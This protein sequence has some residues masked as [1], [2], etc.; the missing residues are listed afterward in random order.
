MLNTLLRVRFL[1]IG[2]WLTGASRKKKSQS[3]GQLIG[4]A[5]LMIYAFGALGFM[6]WHIF[7]TIAL[8]FHEAGL[9][10]LYF[11]MLL[12]MAFALMFVGSVFTAKAQLFEAKDNDLLLSLPLKPGDILLS[13]MFMLAVI[14]LIFGLL[15]AVPAGAVWGRA[16]GFSAAS[17][18][19]YMLVFLMLVLLALAL[20]AL[21]GWLISLLTA[22][23][24]KKS[25]V[26]TLL[27]LIF[28]GAYMYCC[29]N[30]NT[31]I[32]ELAAKPDAAAAAVGAVAPLYRLS[33]AVAA[34]NLLAALPALLFGA[35][36]FAGTYL[37]LS[38]TFMSAAAGQHGGKKLRYVERA[39]KS[40]SA[41]TALFRREMGRFLSC[42]AYMMNSGLGAVMTLAG[43]VLLLIKAGSVRAIAAQMPELGGLLAPAAVMSLCLLSSMT[44]I[45]SP[46]VSLEGRSIW[47]AQSLPVSTKAVLKAKLRL[48]NTI[49]LIPVLFA[50]LAAAVVVQPEGL[51][52]VLLFVLPCL[53]S[54]FVGILGLVENLRHPNLD[55]TNET[56]AVKSGIGVMLTMFI[57]WLA[58][59]VPVVLYF[60]L[61][62]T[63]DASAV[64]AVFS[65]IIA[66]LCALMYRW[67]MTRGTQVYMGL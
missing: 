22:R 26:T 52:L 6:F 48:H 28:L 47:I 4:F 55:W 40:V 23:V 45:S 24:Q 54:V 44:L 66:A 25:L 29:F 53:F 41:D 32:T 15:T 67:L 3:K 5:A 31:L 10:W 35:A 59:A 11:A 1:A 57:S 14:A 34:G 2:S 42:P 7:D 30:L 16:V 56:Q 64:L 13:R 65:L 36:V 51:G 27:S 46:S 21:F 33:A 61:G 18:T 12:I 39:E 62:E 49:S 17:L 60:L 37:L 8:P 20:C 63:L 9:D 19:A 43:A 38:V 50:C 58:L